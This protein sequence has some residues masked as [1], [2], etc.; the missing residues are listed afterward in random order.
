MINERYLIK[1]KLGEGRSKVFLC[2]DIENPSEDV[3]IKILSSTADEVEVENFR[4]EFMILRRLN[5]PSI[6]QALNYGSIVKDDNLSDE[7]KIGSKFFSL[8]YFDGK[9]LLEYEDINNEE[10]LNK[11]ISQICAVL[12]YLHQSDYIY[13]DLKPDNILVKKINEEPVVKLIDMGFAQKVAQKQE[14]IKSNDNKYVKGTAEYIAPELLKNEKHDNRVDLYSLGILL[15]RI[16]YKKFPF[17]TD[18]KL[19]IYKAHLEKDFEYEKSGYSNTLIQ[20]IKKLLEKDPENRYNNSLEILYDLNV[21]INNKITKDWSPAKIFE[22]RR[23][24]LNI[25]DTYINDKSSNELFTIKGFEGS[26]KTAL[27]EELNFIYSNSVL[28]KYDRSKSGFQFLKYFLKKI[29]FNDFVYNNISSEIKNS[30]NDLLKNPSSELLDE[31]K[32]IFAKVTQESNFILILDDFNSYD[33][34]T[35]EMIKDVLPIFQVNKIKIVVTEDSDFD[36]TSKSFHNVKEID[37]TPFTDVQVTELIDKSYNNSFPKE[38]LKKLILLYADLLP[39]SVESFIKDCLQLNIIQYQKDKISINVSD[40]TATLLKSSHDQ[41]YDV[42]LSY[43]SRKGFQA[44][45]MLSIFDMSLDDSALASL[46]EINKDNTAVIIEE[47]RDNNILHSSNMGTKLQFTSESLKRHIYTNIKG[48]EEY[49][50]KAG[51]IIKSKFPDFDRNELARQFELGKDYEACYK[52]LI[53]EVNNAE[54]ISAYS[55]QKKLLQKLLSI[56]LT[57]KYKNEVKYLLSE[58][59]FKLSDYRS[60][61]K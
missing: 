30:I 17:Q 25:L 47:L 26:G 44:A 18:D 23:D 2:N 39:G 5:H 60:L 61:S 21:Q 7:I 14:N 34:F 52:T 4:N 16:V 57:E 59:F 3:A 51:N 10:S 28:I 58:V 42:R 37:L 48:K 35:L 56:S 12:L 13:Y 9:P 50:L 49:H 19:R 54:K 11:I 33:N 55:Y 38:E 15:Y 29:I 22:N 53:E 31:L 46:L 6:I 1:N 45:Q 20:V 43:L 8:E 32:G 41:I 36:Y 27:S 24:V 40:E